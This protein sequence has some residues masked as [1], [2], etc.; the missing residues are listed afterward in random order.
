MQKRQ[1]EMRKQFRENIARWSPDDI[2]SFVLGLTQVRSQGD[3]ARLLK[4]N[5]TI[6]VEIRSWF[7]GLDDSTRCFVATVALFANFS[8]EE[9]W[10]HHK[11]IV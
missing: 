2:E 5:A 7:V 4:R 10:G 8:N 1:R 9:L 11:A 3:I 6:D